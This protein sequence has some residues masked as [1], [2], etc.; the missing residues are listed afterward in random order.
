MSEANVQLNGQHYMMLKF[1]NLSEPQLYLYA[2]KSKDQCMI[3]KHS[4]GSFIHF[5]VVPNWNTGPLGGG[6]A[7][8]SSVGMVSV[9][10]L[11]TSDHSPSFSAKVK[12]E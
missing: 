12:N 3:S 8:G 10:R 5:P 4:K 2:H 7:K 1:I 11:E 6:G 9:Y